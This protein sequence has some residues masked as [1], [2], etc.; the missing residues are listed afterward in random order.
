M[1]IRLTPHGS[2]REAVLA[3]M[4]LATL[5][6]AVSTAAGDYEAVP[7]ANGGRIA[8]QVRV[9]GSPAT[10][11]PLQVFKNKKVCGETVTNDAL[12]MG[13]DGALRY[14]VV[15]LEGV[16]RGL[17]P[18]AETV[19]V[20][21]NRGCHFDPH[22]LTASVGQWLVF[23][24]TDPVLHN[25][26]ARLDGRTLFNIAIPTGREKR[27]P[28]VEPGLIQIDCDVLH[29]WMRAYVFVAR[30]PYH[31][32]SD[33]DGA[34]EIRDIPPG[35]YTVRVWHERLGEQRKE[36]EVAAGKVTTLDFELGR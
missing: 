31:A 5:S 7:V 20:I 11:P 18:E 19:N 1:R 28:L 30:D 6:P 22:V 35:H 9:A 13:H 23:R 26:R 36:V 34:Y 17:A 25:A 21:D 2:L 10:L 29:T 3:G 14:A 15:N 16:R 12:V 24:N 33:L 8:G 32:V 27:R 4:V